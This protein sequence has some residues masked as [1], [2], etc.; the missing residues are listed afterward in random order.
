[1]EQREEVKKQYR[2]LESCFLIF[3]GS[4]ED[5]ELIT[6]IWNSNLLL[7]T[8]RIS[9]FLLY[10]QMQWSS[11]VSCAWWHFEILYFSHQI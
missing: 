6:E 11:T 7:G 10:I 2:N 1:M 8:K 5:K 9:F 4:F 3:F